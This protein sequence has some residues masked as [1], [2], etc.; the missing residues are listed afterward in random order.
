M[1]CRA[2]DAMKT[3][4]PRDRDEYCAECNFIISMLV[5]DLE[6]QMFLEIPFGLYE[7]WEDAEKSGMGDDDE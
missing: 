4:E 5:S 7:D 6:D 3:G 2:C 1:R